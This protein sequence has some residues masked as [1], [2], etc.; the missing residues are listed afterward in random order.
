MSPKNIGRGRIGS[1][2]ERDSMA[3]RQLVATTSH[4]TA[5]KAKAYGL[6][7]RHIQ[8]YKE[9]SSQLIYKGN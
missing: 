6:G 9:A 8:T 4:E 2:A 1:E 3:G 5:K 7:I